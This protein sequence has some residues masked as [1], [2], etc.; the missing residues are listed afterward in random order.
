MEHG[1]IGASMLL[2]QLYLLVVLFAGGSAVCDDVAR[3]DAAMT[4]WLW[5]FP[6]LNGTFELDGYRHTMQIRRVVV[7]RRMTREE[8]LRR[9]N[10]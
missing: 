1:C 9:I 10:R 2:L 5:L 3:D 7:R 4:K 8:W 6:W